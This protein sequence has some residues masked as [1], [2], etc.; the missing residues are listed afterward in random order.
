MTVYL[1]ILWNLSWSGEDDVVDWNENKLDKVANK[2]HN[3]ESHE[4]GIKDL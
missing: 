1:S 4:A 2:T 3:N